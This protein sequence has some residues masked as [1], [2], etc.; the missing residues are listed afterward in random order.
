[1]QRLVEMVRVA[2]RLFFS[3][4]FNARVQSDA[5]PEETEEEAAARKN[6]KADKAAALVAK[7]RGNELYSAK[8]RRRVALLYVSTT[9]MLIGTLTSTETEQCRVALEA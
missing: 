3:V 1:M 7:K 8:V 4:W 5:D 2:L 6:L 9:A